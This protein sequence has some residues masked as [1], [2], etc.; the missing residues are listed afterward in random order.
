MANI[1][2]HKKNQKF[3]AWAWASNS[4]LLKV[5]LYLLDWDTYISTSILDIYWLK[6][7][8]QKEVP[9]GLRS[10]AYKERDKVN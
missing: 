2:Y 9:W 8:L 1:E 3:G 5:T 10:D 6:I 4:K 7:A